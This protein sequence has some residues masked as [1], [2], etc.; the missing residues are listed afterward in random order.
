M[1]NLAKYGDG[2]GAGR[3]G[4]DNSLLGPYVPSL[5]VALHIIT[6][7]LVV[8]ILVALLRWLWRKGGK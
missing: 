7:F 1:M 5:Y 4:V 3:G 2:W 8:A 6:W